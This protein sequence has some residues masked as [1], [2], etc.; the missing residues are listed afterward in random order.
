MKA[1]ILAAGYGNRMRPL[2][3]KMHKT[4]LVVN[5]ETIIE[6]IINSLLDHGVCKIVVV[7][8]YLADELTRFLED[9]YPGLKLIFIHNTRYRE[10]NN[11]Y[12]LSLAMNAIQLD[13]DILLIESDLIYENSVLERII[14][15]R[16]GNV[17]LVDHFRSG[18]DGTVVTVSEGVITAIIPPHLQDVN[19]DFSDK[20]KTLN[21]YKFSKVFC[22]EIFRQLL[23]YY[24][25]VID[26]NS[27]YELVLGILIYIQKETI[28]AEILDGEHWS[29]VDDPNDLRVAEFV[30][31]K[32]RR[33][34][35]LAETFGGYWN[36]D[37]LDFCFIRNMYFPNTSILSEMKNNI[38]LLIQNYGSRQ[39]ILNQKLAYFLLCEPNR[40][41]LLNGASQAYPWLPELMGGSKTLIPSPTFGEYPRIFPDTVEYS[42]QIG[43]SPDEITRKGKTCALV[44][45]VNP[46]NPTGTVL[47]SR[48]IQRYAKENPGK[49][50]LVDESFIDFSNIPSMISLLEQDPLQNVVVLKSLSKALGVPGLRIGFLYTANSD[51]HRKVMAKVPIWNA[52]SIAEY[53]LEIIL[54]HRKSV[55]DSFQKTICDRESF[56][57]NLGKYP[58]IEAVYPSGGNFI[59]VEFKTNPKM[60]DLSHWLL[61]MYSI[62][63]KDVSSRFDNGRIYCRFAV[64][65]PEE[66]ER[67]ISGIRDYFEN[68][69]TTS[70][71]NALK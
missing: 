17:A 24:T 27:Y 65:L 6:R 69:C 18:M 29:E 50:V 38:S 44:I 37:I 35:I 16:H 66:N 28:H 1:I 49:M 68:S 42:D 53:F 2:T 22:R 59:L 62:Y 46:N 9:R 60:E 63:V 41:V 55:A 14:R 58:F 33:M 25:K 10:T 20:Y 26:V 71:D 67:L 34:Q 47:D 11:I 12:S 45:F 64:R 30:F 13:D 40:L 61:S 19:F 48:W 43:I 8:G 54:K 4:L 70:V 5:N 39:E 23:D 32:N 51:I 7:T 31:N 21:I 36:H 3:D 52:N 57:E 56:R 15:S